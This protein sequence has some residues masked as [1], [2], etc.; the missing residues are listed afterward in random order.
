MVAGPEAEDDHCD[1]QAFE[2]RPFE[3]DGETGGITL[4]PALGGRTGCGRAGSGRA[5]GRTGWPRR[6]RTRTRAVPRPAQ[7]LYL[8]TKDGVLVVFGL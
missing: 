5:G 8:L 1:L 3:S 7:R 6:A 4:G 2:E